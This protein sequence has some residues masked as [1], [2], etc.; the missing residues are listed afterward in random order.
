M[1][2]VQRQ[3]SDTHTDVYL[4]CVGMAR[5]V[6]KHIFRCKYFL[7]CDISKE[8]F[9]TGNLSYM[10]KIYVCIQQ[11]IKRIIFTTLCPENATVHAHIFTQKKKF[12]RKASFVFICDAVDARRW[13]GPALFYHNVIHMQ[14]EL[15]CLVETRMHIFL[16]LV[17]V[18]QLPYSINPQPVQPK[19]WGCR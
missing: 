2:T 13:P 16:Q 17:S 5:R 7:K 1:Y 14:P 19:N 3:N 8:N 4:R 6:K 9:S 15:R 10:R 12:K 11:E 18:R